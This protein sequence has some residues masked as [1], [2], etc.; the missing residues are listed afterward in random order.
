MTSDLAA[1]LAAIET[2][3][4]CDAWPSV[5]VI[6][7]DIRPVSAGL[8]MAGAACTASCRNDFL[9]VLEA[10]RAAAPGDVL[11]VDGG[12]GRLALAGELFATEAKRKG[13][14][15]I[16]VD[17]AVR[18]VATIRA[19]GLPVYARSIHAKA[20]ASLD[21]QQI[22]QEIRCGGIAIAG[23]A[24]AKSDDALAVS[25]VGLRQSCGVRMGRDRRHRLIPCR[26]SWIAG[27]SSL[28]LPGS[29]REMNSYG[30]ANEY[31]K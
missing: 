6:D 22:Q 29:P 31:V 21:L 30:E 18:D 2:S 4:L 15:G 16:V 25:R 23:Q 8:K 9:A 24:V 11:V 12:A 1:R 28:D 3:C 13:L 5:R 10:L 14:A 7:P 19:L 17:G 20:G 26:R 27:R